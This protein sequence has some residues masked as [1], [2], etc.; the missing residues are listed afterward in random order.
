LRKAG[1]ARTLRRASCAGA[2][3][4]GRLAGMVVSLSGS[5]DRA[6]KGSSEQIEVTVVANECS[7]AGFGYLRGMS[8][9]SKNLLGQRL[10]YFSQ[11][12]F[13]GV[14]A[15]WLRKQCDGIYS[16]V[17][18]F[19][20]SEHC[21]FQISIDDLK[22]GELIFNSVLNEKSGSNFEKNFD[23]EVGLA[24]FLFA[25][26]LA[27]KPSVVV[28][29]GVANGITTNLIM[30]ALERTGGTLHS[31]DI[32][33]KTQNVYVG[34]G[35]WYFHHLRGDLEADLQTQIN[36]IGAVDLWIH[37][38][39]HGYRWQTFEYLLAAR[40]LTADG[41]LVSDDIDSSTAWGLASEHILDYSSAIFDNRKFIGVA[42]IKS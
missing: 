7:C 2:A 20:Q 13:H 26:I 4:V 40:V 5:A 25:F 15:N 35:N 18:L 36:Q 14:S 17:E 31:F 22:E 10:R 33:S 42:R 28:E 38:S 29:T 34:R 21:P 39:N 24:S 32:E 1:I 12:N 23:C 16:N 6:I 41:T 3:G 30:K 9:R 19:A 27:K 37:D 11:G 8:S